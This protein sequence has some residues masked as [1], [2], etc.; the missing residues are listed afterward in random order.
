MSTTLISYSA[1]FDSTHAMQWG[2]LWAN[3]DGRHRWHLVH[4]FEGEGIRD[5]MVRFI[6]TE[7][8]GDFED[9]AEGY[10]GAPF[11]G[12]IPPGHKAAW[13]GQDGADR[14]L[15]VW[16]GDGSSSTYE[17]CAREES[18]KKIAARAERAAARLFARESD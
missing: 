18:G 1:A 15:S 9:M 5:V 7:G 3:I 8:D 2:W 10:E 12:L 11:V 16:W 13:D 14:R 6:N 17:W 4:T